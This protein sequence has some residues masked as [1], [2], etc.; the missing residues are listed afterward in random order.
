VAGPE[1]AR[2][3]TALLDSGAE[4]NFISQLVVKDLEL[5]LKPYQGGAHGVAGHPLHIY[6]L[7]QA[8]VT[9]VD[10]RGASGTHTMPFISTNLKGFDV[11]LGMP[12]LR[13]VDPSVSWKEGS[14]AYRP[15]GLSG[16]EEATLADI[17]KAERSG[18][19]V[20]AVWVT[21]ESR[22]QVRSIL[23]YTVTSSSL[24]LPAEFADFA[25]VFSE[26]GAGSLPDASRVVHSIDLAE[27]KTAPWGPIYA[28][29][30]R[31]LRIL[32]EYLESSMEKGWIQKS[33]SP[34]GAPILFVPKKDGTL[35]LCVDYRRLNEVTIKNRHP[36][37]LISETIDRLSGAAVY[38]KL[39]LRDAY[40]RIPIKESDRW[41]TAFR[42]RY[43]HFEYTVMPFG[44]TNAP[45]TFQAY[46]NQALAGYLDITCVAFMDDILIY[47]ADPAEHTEHVRQVLERLRQYSLYAK[48]SKC[49]FRTDCVDFL[50]Y[51]ISTG[52]VAMDPS[53]VQAIREWPT[54]ESYREIQVFIGFANFYRGFIKGY[55]KITQAI[56]NLLVGMV[57]GVKSGPFEW[58]P[59][60]D[61][62]FHEL[63]AAFESADMLQHFDPTRESRI[64][65]DASGRATGA[66]LTQKNLVEGKVVWKPVAFLSKKMTP[67]E[68]NYTTGDQEMLAIV[69]AFKEW[70]HY[71]EAPM[72]T[73][74]VLTDHEAL[75]SFMGTK[76]LN[77]RQARWA[78]TLAAF[79]FVIEYR[80][81]KTN[82][83]DPL[84]RRPDHMRGEPA[85]SENTIRD[86]FLSRQAL[87][88]PVDQGEAAGAL[89]AMITRSSR[90][91]RRDLPSGDLR[92]V[93]RPIGGETVAEGSRQGHATRAESQRSSSP[94][95]P[96]KRRGRV[97]SRPIGGEAV[98][99]GSLQG[100]ATRVESQRSSSPRP[101]PKRRGRPRKA[102]AALGARRQERDVS[103]DEVLSSNSQ[104]EGEEAQ[105][106]ITNPLFPSSIVSLI[107]HLQANDTW[108]KE[109]KWESEP[110]RENTAGTEE[111]LWAVDSNGLV[112]HKGR[113]FVPN[114]PAV[115]QEILRVNHDDPWQGG[116]FGR[117]RTLKMIRNYYTWPE[118]HR[119]VREY[120]ATCDVC[121]RK[122]APRHKPYGLLQPLPKAE[123]P[124]QDIALDFITGLPPSKHLGV[125]YDAILVVVDRYSRMSVYLPCH[126]S[127]TASA[128]ADR[129]LDG[130]FAK[131]GVPR[132]IVSDRGTTFTSSFWGTFCRDLAVKRCF[133]TAFH[134]QTD[135]Q[136]ERMN[137]TLEVYLRCYTND[138][139][140]NWAG[141]LS[142]AEWASNSHP[143]AAT[144]M[145][146][147]NMVFRY[148]PTL[149]VNIEPPTVE[150]DSAAGRN[151]AAAIE[152][153]L[154]NA[155]SRVNQAEEAM[156]RYYDKK[157][158]PR[159]Y[160]EGEQVLLASKYIRLRKASAKLSD[161]F[162]G[163]FVIEKRI[164]TRAYRLKLPEKYGRVHHTFHVSLLEPYRRRPGYNPPPPQ[165]I[166]GEL[167]H[168]IELIVAKHSENNRTQYKVRWK[169]YGPD[170]D[171]WHFEEDLQHA[172][173]AIKE[174]EETG[175]SL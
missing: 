2:Q 18:E 11:I 31:E 142:S 77:R 67:A 132:S 113:V 76:T 86:L 62:A 114:D 34:A 36:L 144:G 145:S 4:A 141:L 159:E 105:D 149:Y 162:L 174:F 128:L 122:K 29:N 168:V 48:L 137:Q 65:T 79:D 172:R 119:D 37:P 38:T 85:R 88:E 9:A 93:S 63:K 124:W 147:F 171:T 40:H 152:E 91:N 140:D 15:E 47:S 35:R 28:L 173:D 110:V 100:H 130:V 50:G 151:R 74:R 163:P 143:A 59:E 6:G 16:I 167:E 22:G 121:Q 12:W 30:P 53:R 25:D 161:K 23:A 8:P 165:E 138:A 41:K 134:P 51:R 115:R 125:V 154:R 1:G 64:E 148:S 20:Y 75:K 82:P 106:Q 160:Q 52:G 96:P 43:G 10:K 89:V 32:R 175:R 33:E 117:E 45:A 57:K 164:G 116:H 118:L 54:P 169:G 102:P 109:R 78:E 94:R 92:V 49:E 150:G 3:I 60:A 87:P 108:C 39:D 120:V 170:E 58:T 131:Y 112:R 129:M 98:A 123:S 139:Q 146:P 133:S 61:R 153:A 103:P 56:T 80:A 19:R 104:D 13:E 21:P 73:V 14:W 97:A 7:A 157:H 46:I 99:E 5:P 68:L 90:L 70:R 72:E 127:T 69:Q 156:I 66:V 111:Q 155:S 135:G 84:S 42:T 27:G 126:T 24:T 83:A 166:E 136:T 55:S 101:P 158:K 107:L 71:L 26:E 95:P 44:L 81:G 17:Q